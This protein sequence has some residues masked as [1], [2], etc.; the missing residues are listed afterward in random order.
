MLSSFLG[1]DG[2]LALFEPANM[3]T[4]FDIDPSMGH[5]LIELN[6]NSGSLPVAV[7]FNE[8]NRD[9]IVE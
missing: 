1:E 7:F 4:I 5:H 3:P 6:Y 2:S 8:L 9:L